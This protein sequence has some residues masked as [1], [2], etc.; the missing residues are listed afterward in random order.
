MW[1]KQNSHRW[2]KN[3]NHNWKIGAGWVHR[4]TIN[5]RWQPVRRQA[6]AGSVASVSTFCTY[7]PVYRGGLLSMK[8]A[9]PSCLSRVGITW[10]QGNRLLPLIQGNRISQV[11]GCTNSTTVQKLKEV[12]SVLVRSYPSITHPLYCHPWIHVNLEK[13]GFSHWCHRKSAIWNTCDLWVTLYLHASVDCL[14]CHPHSHRSLGDRNKRVGYSD[15][16]KTPYKLLN[17]PPCACTPPHTRHVEGV[18]GERWS[19]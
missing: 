7:W 9:M 15:V 2:Q 17:L 1:Q 4:H 16:N 18:S 3:G 5:V 13:T 19:V 10:R 14:L 11:V 8:A 6:A 12:F